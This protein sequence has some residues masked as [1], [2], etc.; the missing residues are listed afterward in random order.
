MAASVP[1]AAFEELLDVGIALS[2]TRDLRT[3]L[4]RIVREA[5]R[6]TTADA[7]TLY[8][9]AKDHLK[10][11]VAHNETF[12][13]RWGE[14]KAAKVFRTFT[15]AI[16]PH[17][18]AGA[19][20]AR[21]EI[22]NVPDVQALGPDSP[23]QY[24]PAFD[25]AFEYETRANL[26]V[27]MLTPG[28]EVVG[29]LQLINARSKGGAVAA[30]GE[31]EVHLA[32]ALASQAAVALQNAL[33]TESLRA[34]HLDTLSR[35]GVAAEWR[36]KETANHIVRV[37]EYCVILAEG[38]GWKPA[39]VELLRLSA[40]MHD[41]GKLGIPDDILHKPGKLEPEERKVMETH[42][43]IGANIM[44]RAGN[45]VM[46]WSRTIALGHHEKW[47]GSGYPQRIAG[48]SIPLTCQLTAI[49]DVYDALSSRRPYK[50][51]FPEEKVLAIFREDRGRAF[52]P[53]LVDLLFD[54]LDRFREIRTRLADNESEFAKFRDYANIVLEPE[55]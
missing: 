18:I 53:S 26:A 40:P 25:R 10:A 28:G 50:E 21:R 38:L 48:E 23:F 13:A 3:L 43:L 33:L 51:P 47:D 27:P 22:V 7:A 49:A 1:A 15:V 30:F 14:E 45:E 35:L 16:D 42:T 34:A 4:T 46:R 11:E 41:V 2:S 32:R 55:A 5:C 31:A 24:N 39:E 44:A 37:S 12:L 20:A 9:A 36:D 8:L 54:R 6:F 19:A 17:S 52:R 29:V